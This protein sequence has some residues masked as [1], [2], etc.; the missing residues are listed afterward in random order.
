MISDIT[1]LFTD[2]TGTSHDP[3]HLIMV[4]LARLEKLI[5][6][7]GPRPLLDRY[8]GPAEKKRFSAFKLAKRKKEWLG[9]RIAGK[10]AAAALPI[11]QDT[12]MVNLEINQNSQDKPFIRLTRGQIINIS[13]SHSHDLAVAMASSSPCGIDIE[14]VSQKI[15]R[16]KERFCQEQELTQLKKWQTAKQNHL[17]LLTM[18]W[19]AKESLKKMISPMPGFLELELDHIDQLRIFSFHSSKQSHY[20]ANVSFISHNYSIAICQENRHEKRL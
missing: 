12:P 15:E 1:T 4:N 3:F 7:D 11:C 19:C 9:G 5:V 17:Q 20:Q 14:Q 10:E 6:A 16:V 8:L 13:I 18:L 2:L